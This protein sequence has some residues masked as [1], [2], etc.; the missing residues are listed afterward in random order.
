MG[1]SKDKQVKKSALLKKLLAVGPENR[2]QLILL[3]ISG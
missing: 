3:H 2:S 1:K